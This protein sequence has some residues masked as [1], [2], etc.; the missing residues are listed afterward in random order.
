MANIPNARMNFAEFITPTEIY[1]VNICHLRKA[2]K[3]DFETAEDRP[4][5][6]KED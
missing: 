5:G 1:E 2:V 6:V 4:L 3:N